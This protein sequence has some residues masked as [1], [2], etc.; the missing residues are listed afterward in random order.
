M[1]IYVVKRQKTIEP[2]DKRAGDLNIG[3]KKLS[4]WI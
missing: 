3:N 2:F 1:K 4:V